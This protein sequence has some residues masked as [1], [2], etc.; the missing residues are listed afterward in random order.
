VAI[1][2]L[3]MMA[4]RAS[5]S[6]GSTSRCFGAGCDQ[7]LLGGPADLVLS[8]MAANATGH[9]ATDHIKIMALAEAA[10]EMAHDVLKPVARFSARCCKAAPSRPCWRS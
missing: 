7:G 9:R 1:D 3:D 8:D 4:I 10:A 2:L 5:N 6:S